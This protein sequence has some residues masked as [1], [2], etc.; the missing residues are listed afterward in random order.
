[1]SRFQRTLKKYRVARWVGRAISWSMVPFIIMA[2]KNPV[3]T[4]TWLWSVFLFPY[5]GPLAYL[6]FGSDRMNRRRLRGRQQAKAEHT[7]GPGTEDFDA[8]AGRILPTLDPASAAVTRLLARINEHATSAAAGVRVLVDA[9]KF[10]PALI[11]RIHAARKHVHVEFFI[12]RDDAPGTK[13]RDALVAAA[14]RGVEVRLLVDTAGSWSTPGRFFRPLTE[15]GG[16]FA[17]FRTVSPV[18]NRWS[19]SLRNHRKLQ[20]IDGER[21]F[22]GG[23][24]VG[25]EYLGQDPREGFWR[26]AQIELHGPVAA[27]LQ[28]TFADDWFFATEER[29]E[30]DGYYPDWNAAGLA[31]PP[32]R[33]LV[34][35]MSDGPDTREDPIQMSVVAL[36]NAARGRAWLTAGYFVPFEPL[37]T[38][39]KLCAGRGVDCRLM[40]SSKSD[41]PYLV[42]VGR[43]YYEELLEHGVRIFEYQRGINHA[44]VATF[45][46]RWLMVGSANFDVRSMRLNFEL[47]ALVDDADQAVE[48]ETTLESDFSRDALEIDLETFR[49]RGRG[50]R[51]LEQVFRPLAPLL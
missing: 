11:E 42:Y 45:D 44:K 32:A 14:R 31:R 15:A 4:L 43:S 18:Q 12:W 38:A 25:R 48:L 22:V 40:I 49:R 30:A 16:K 13:L 1:M 6:V 26:D 37:L 24:N 23:M 7:S 34:Q 19:I 3:S 51:M 28:Q 5:V 39:L 21:A 20:V 33:H 2:P 10:Y 46:S 36:L 9:D 47:N 29:L 8:A 35:V 27:V 17:W 41:H 50:Q